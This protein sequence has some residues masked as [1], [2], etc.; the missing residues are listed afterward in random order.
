[1]SN[2]IYKYTLPNSGYAL[3][4]S[5]LNKWNAEAGNNAPIITSNDVKAM[6][7]VIAA[8]PPSAAVSTTTAPWMGAGDKSNGSLYY[9]YTPS[10]VAPSNKIEYIP[11][12]NT[13]LAYPYVSTYSP[14]ASLFKTFEDKQKAEDSKQQAQTVAL[15]T[16]IE[17][18]LAEAIKEN[19]TTENTS[20][21]IPIYSNTSSSGSAQAAYDAQLK[22]IEEQRAY[23]EQ[24]A[25][26]ARQEAIKNAYLN[27]D[28]ALPTYGQNAERLA[29]MGLSNSGYSDYLG[30]VA[31]SSM[32]GG[33]QDAHKTANDAIRD[34]YYNAELQKAQAVDTLYNRQV[35]EQNEYYNRQLQ[36]QQAAAEEATA[37]KAK[38]EEFLSAASY[39]D[40]TVNQVETLAKI[41]GFTQ[42]QTNVLIEAVKKYEAYMKEYEDS[43]NSF[44]D[45]K[46]TTGD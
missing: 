28:R 36:S 7:D 10:A 42:E 12:N 44:F 43:L 41:Y 17:E 23:L 30:G 31:Y 40:Y 13:D 5:S 32:V 14:E 9:N 4:A 24:L 34:A 29:Q 18:A 19:K 6:G 1:M 16:Q 3:V 26:Q 22:A 2:N 15:K 39:G 21:I 35:A 11:V 45:D 37:Q 25:E 20:G 8:Y 46:E 38:F 27:Y 33:V